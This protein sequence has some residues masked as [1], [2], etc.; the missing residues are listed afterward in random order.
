MKQNLIIQEESL[1]GIIDMLK[2]L[3]AQLDEKINCAV[4]KTAEPQ[5][6]SSTYEEREVNTIFLRQP[7]F[8]FEGHPIIRFP[9]VI[10]PARSPVRLQSAISYRFRQ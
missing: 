5:V 7:N 1:A 3:I 8:F 10:C 4:K 9:A 2:K 6:H